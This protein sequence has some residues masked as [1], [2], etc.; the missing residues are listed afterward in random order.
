MQFK[1]RPPLALG[2]LIL[3]VSIELAHM[4]P[5]TKAEADV[6]LQEQLPVTQQESQIYDPEFSLELQPNKCSLIQRNR[7]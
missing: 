6:Q 2:F 4:L 3:A 7:R 5:S 1:Q